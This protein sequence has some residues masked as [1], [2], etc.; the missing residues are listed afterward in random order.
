MATFPSSPVVGNI[1]TLNNVNYTWNGY[2]WSASAPSY[3]KSNLDVD[4]TTTTPTSENVLAYNSSTS[5]WV[6]SPRYIED[7]PF[8]GNSVVWENIL[9]ARQDTTAIFGLPT[10]D[11]KMRPFGSPN[12]LVINGGFFNNINHY[13]IGFNNTIKNGIAIKVP[14]GYGAVF[15]RIDS[16]Y[17]QPNMFVL[18]SVWESSANSGITYRT[19]TFNNTNEYSNGAN[20]VTPYGFEQ[21]VFKNKNHIWRMIGLPDKLGGYL[22]LSN[23]STTNGSGNAICGLGFAENPYNLTMTT[24]TDLFDNHNAAAIPST[25]G[26]L[27]WDSFIICDVGGFLWP[28]FF[29][30]LTRAIPYVKS[31]YDKM[32]VL[33]TYA[34]AGQFTAL[35]NTSISI[36]SVTVPEKNMR[37]G[38]DTFC[39]SLMNKL[40]YANMTSNTR[41]LNLLCLRVPAARIAANTVTAYK[42][43]FFQLGI[44]HSTTS[45][46]QYFGIQKVYVYDIPYD[47]N[48]QY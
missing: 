17:Q 7:R 4:L 23:A 48:N 26:G 27:G 14:A 19:A 40:R 33:V 13:N 21:K 41:Q 30:T 37:I 47:A 5:K 20:E 39:N 28:G 25:G 15:Y 1:Y 34:A 45:S 44:D 3:L 11:F 2:A 29:T 22:Y 24:V 10:V 18:D 16:F 31:G 9:D 43:R 42:D 35:P 36:N 8:F 6:A 32:V 38:N 12:N 46:D